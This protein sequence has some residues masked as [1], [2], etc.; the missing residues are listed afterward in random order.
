MKKPQIIAMGG[1]GFSMEPENPLLDKYFLRQTGKRTPRVCFLPTASGD[2]DTYI[3]TFYDAFAKH[4]CQPS[5]LSL[6]YPPERIE[7]FVLSQD[8]IYVGGGNTKSMLALWK[9]WRLDKILRKA[10]RQGVV[11]GGL[12][13][14]SICWFEQGLT[15][16]ISDRLTVLPCLGFL[17]GS[18]CPHYDSEENRR[19]AFKRLVKGGRM[20]DGLA[21]EDGVALHFI[22]KKLARIVSS[23]PGAAAF[24]V[25]KTG[26]TVHEEKLPPTYLGEK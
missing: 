26:D 16:S 2:S 14:G 20:K 10:W 22:G 7:S 11:L 23:R 5:H 4:R 9:E 24:R 6:F 8:A 19:P 3:V 18:H 15:D 17:A 13:A 1:G 12:S 21:A 25:R